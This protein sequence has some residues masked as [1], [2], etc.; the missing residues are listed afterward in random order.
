[1]Y[2]LVRTLGLHQVLVRQ[3]PLLSVSLLIAEIFYKFHS[4][5]LE[6]I[7]FLGTWYVLD[8]V[9]QGVLGFWEKRNETQ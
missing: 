9:A 3:L 1:M 4:L 8:A 5:L 7:A 2:L 6:C